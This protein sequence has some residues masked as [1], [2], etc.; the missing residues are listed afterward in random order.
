MIYSVTTNPEVAYKE[1]REALRDILPR[2]MF[3]A[4]YPEQKQ[5]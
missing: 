3:F 4:T 2:I 1:G 5:S